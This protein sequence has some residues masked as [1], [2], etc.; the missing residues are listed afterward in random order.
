MAPTRNAPPADNALD[1]ARWRA[2]LDCPTLHV[3]LTDGFQQLVDGTLRV[4]DVERARI[5]VTL[6]SQPSPSDETGRRAL[7]LFVDERL[8]RAA[9]GSGR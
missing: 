5:Q 7:T 6:C 1:A 4:V 2:L 9:L 8:K 3:R